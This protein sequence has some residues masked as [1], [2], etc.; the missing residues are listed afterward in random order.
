MENIQIVFL[1]TGWFLEGLDVWRKFKKVFATIVK[2]F[3][4]VLLLNQFYKGNCLNNP[5]YNILNRVVEASFM[6]IIIK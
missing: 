3:L 6:K 2:T 1:S 4:K 5:D